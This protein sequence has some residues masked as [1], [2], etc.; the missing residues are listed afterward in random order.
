MNSSRTANY[1]W[2]RKSNQKQVRD[3]LTNDV[4]IKN[5]VHL[6]MINCLKTGGDDS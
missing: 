6:K 1:L 2:R 5:K 3:I 4:H